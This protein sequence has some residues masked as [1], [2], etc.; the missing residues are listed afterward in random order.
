MPMKSYECDAPPCVHVVVDEAQK[1]FAVFI[2]DWDGNI[3]LIK[4]EEI[5]KAANAIR[6]VLSEGYKEAIP[7]QAD[8]LA[9]KYLNAEPI[10]E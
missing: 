5:L 3:L 8:Y 4:A 1:I 6:E 2:E 7:T 9:R 10:E